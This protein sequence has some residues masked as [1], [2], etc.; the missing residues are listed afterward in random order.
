VDSRSQ[1]S[2]GLKSSDLDGPFVTAHA[3]SVEISESETDLSIKTV[4]REV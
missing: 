1:Q 2:S 4:A 3:Y